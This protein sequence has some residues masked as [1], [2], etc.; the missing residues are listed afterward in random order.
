M[1]LMAPPGTAIAGKVSRDL[2][3]RPGTIAL[4]ALAA[5]AGGRP[6]TAAASTEATAPAPTCA[7]AATHVAALE[8][9]AREEDDLVARQTAL[10]TTCHAK[11]WN[12]SER[13]CL[14]AASSV[15]GVIECE[16]VARIARGDDLGGPACVDVEAHKFALFRS[17][18][19]APREDV[20]MKR[21]AYR[22]FCRARSRAYKECVLAAT[23]IPSHGVC[24]K[25]E[26]GD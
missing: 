3:R 19:L 1:T 26:L 8:I 16:R 13:R 22:R 17:S 18:G 2:P 11:G 14:V 5:C 24:V 15:D 23:T 10:R 7:E 25:R 20:D 9:A 12:A 21:A 4:L 6:P